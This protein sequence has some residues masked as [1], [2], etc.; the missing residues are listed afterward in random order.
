MA[1]TPIRRLDLP[2]QGD[3][4]ASGLWPLREMDADKDQEWIVTHESG[5]GVRIGFVGGRAV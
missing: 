2:S 1:V 3:R 4:V 5:V